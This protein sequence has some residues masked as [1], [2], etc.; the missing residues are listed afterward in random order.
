LRQGKAFGGWREAG[1]MR[2]ALYCRVSKNDES[3]DPQNQLEPLRSYAG[4]L[5]GEVVEV[6]KK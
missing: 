6:R 3:Q 2:I 1:K 5:G 4:A